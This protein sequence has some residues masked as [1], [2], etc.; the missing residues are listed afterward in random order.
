VTEHQAISEFANLC[1]GYSMDRLAALK[2]SGRKV[3]HYTSAENG[4]NILDSKTMWLRNAVAMNDFSEIAWGQRCLGYCLD[5]REAGAR[6]RTLIEASH[7]GAYDIV[8]N[9]LNVRTVLNRS[10]TYL[11]SLSEFDPGDRLGKLSM[12]RAYGGSQAGVA[13]V[14]NTAPLESESDA[15]AI[16]HSPVLYGDEHALAGEFE[17]LVQRLENNVDLLPQVPAPAVSQIVYNALHFATLSTKHPGFEE[18]REWRIIHSPLETRSD[19][20]VEDVVT[21]RGIPQIIYKVPLQDLPGLEMPELELASLLYRVIIGPCQ[22]PQ[23]VGEAYAR[24]MLSLGIA[25]PWERIV[26]SEIPLRQPG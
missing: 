6:L 17:R 21:V 20:V 25:Q 16:Y 2:D 22:Y 4:L 14:F 15:L 24:V 5:S 23:Q 13:L 12:W 18:E 7:P 11:T 8:L 9:W 10:Y 19:W 3:A 26:L 1:F